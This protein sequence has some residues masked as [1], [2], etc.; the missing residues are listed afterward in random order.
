MNKISREIMDVIKLMVDGLHVIPSVKNGYTLLSLSKKGYKGSFI[1]VEK[2]SLWYNDKKYLI[3]NQ[4][5]V[6]LENNVKYFYK[7]NRR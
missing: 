5:I 2:S 1:I 4:N 3:N 7:H 6:S